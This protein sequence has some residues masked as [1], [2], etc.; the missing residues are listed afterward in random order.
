LKSKVKLQNFKLGIGRRC[1]IAIYPDK[2]PLAE[3]IRLSRLELFNQKQRKAY[4]NQTIDLEDWL[5]PVVYSNQPVNFNLREFTP[6]EEEKYWKFLDRQYRFP[7][8]TYGFIGR[9]LEILKIEKALLK[10]NILLLRGM[11][12]TGKTTLLSYLR[13][14]WQRTHY[15]EQIFYFGYDEKAWTLEQ[16]LFDIG[17]QVYGRFEQAK[18]QAMSQQAQVQKL[19][20][21]LRSESQ[22]LMLDN[23]ESITGQKL[24]IQNT[25]P[26]SERN[27]IKDFLERLAGGETK[28]IFGSRS[29][30]EWLQE[31]TFRQNI[32]YLQGLDR[33]SRSDLAEEILKQTIGEKKKIEKIKADDDFKRL[34]KLLAGYPLAME[35]VLANL[36]QQN[37]HKILEK[38][39]AADISLDTGSEEKTESILKCV[40]YSHSNLSPEAQKLLL[41]LAP[42]SSFI[43]RR[44]IS[45]YAKELQALE[46]FQYYPFDRFDEAIQ[47]A[48]NW[49]LLSPIDEDRPD[50]LTIQ[51][52]FPYFLKTKV[53]QLDVAT[54]QALTEGFKNHYL[55]LAN[56][57]KSWMES[58]DAQERRSGIVFCGWEYENL[59]N[60]LQICLEKQETVDIFF[61]LHQYFNLTNDIQS[62]LKLSEFV[63]QK[64]ESYPDE[65]CAGDIR[66]EIL[67]SLER[68]ANCYSKIKNHQKA[69]E[70][71]LKIV[72]AT[73]QS[74]GIE[75]TQK[76]SL[77]ANTYHNLGS[78]ASELREW[79]EA[80]RY[81]QQAL[82]IK[83]EYGDR[84]SQASTYHN[85]GAIAEELREWEE[86]R[87][88]YQQALAIKIEYGDRFSQA[89][90]YHNLG[91]VAS[92]LREWEEAR[93]YYQQ[94]L[95]IDIEYGDRFSQAETYHQLGRV[96]QQ[97]R[98][99]EEARHNY[100]QALAIKI[101]YGNRFSQASTYHNLGIVASELREWEEARRYYQQALEI[102]IEYGDRFSQ[103]KTYHEL[104]IVASELREWDEARRY[105]Q[106]ALAICVEYG[107][108]FSQATI[109]HNLG[110]IAEELREWEEARRYY[111]QALEI[112]I[113]Y[114]DRYEQ[115]KTYHN[116]GI[117]ASELREWDEARRYY[118][119]ALEIK[120]EYGD[121]FSQAKTYHELG[122]VASE[123][124]E[125]DEARRYY[126][127]AL[128][129]DI[130]YGNRFS[131]ALTYHQL[132][133]V[134][135]QLREWEEARRYY[136]Q[137]LEIKIEYGDRFSQ[138]KTYHELGIVASELREWEEARRYYQQALEIKIEYGNR[139]SQALTYHQLGNLAQQ[140]REWEE[141]RRYYQQALAIYVEYSE[142]Y[143]QANTY[144]ELGIVASELREWEEAKTNY[145][146]ALQI[147]AEFNDEYNLETFSLPRLAH[148]YQTTQDES[149][150]T[151]A[152]SILGITIEELKEGLSQ[153]L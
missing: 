139:F 90:T 151:A 11:G 43:D 2:K 66:F 93:R 40:E 7:L 1:A 46:P 144:H 42:F 106:Q 50:L 123:L 100:Q 23:L 111:Q 91:I 4:F 131:Q 119:Q 56:F 110:A 74:S 96:A 118:Q 145:L 16:I 28:V 99:W 140:L 60:A 84:F 32:Y 124:R 135:H 33:E 133:I 30:E 3:A 59:F 128:E 98:E 95:E 109:Y 142:H 153:F 117:V 97:L 51:P 126:Q 141:A 113:E 26:E 82:A 69:R 9:D 105:Y 22:V 148:F 112:K 37:P 121:R 87:R 125:W 44:Y 143:E 89:S 6:E 129:I 45:N 115:A 65:I 127:Q 101:E 88:Y 29:G 75:E 77:F 70:F 78:V 104:G 146:Q 21:K 83:I 35:V 116:L 103:A 8:P 61:C 25:L 58:N 49:R 54:R 52:V 114:N 34:M 152:A 68:L 64:Q 71:Y 41:C 79:E 18:F 57:Y 24:A 130:E 85:L 36:K 17:K 47:E 63:C 134:A 48:I 10:H 67:L 14:W 132:G 31:R 13:E 81:Y 27:K 80:R 149:I 120:I 5:L 15:A 147:W 86:A 150:L 20:Q 53:N 19:V 102:K 107:D 62:N 73:Q 138:A 38:L 94:A 136:Q 55:W 72:K 122:I 39:Q 137:A 12:G 108:R 92:E 76:Q